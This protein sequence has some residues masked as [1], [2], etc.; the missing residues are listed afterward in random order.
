MPKEVLPKKYNPAQVEPKV[1][2]SWEK[3]G[4]FN[5]DKLPAQLCKKNA[6]PYTIVI[7]PPNIT[8]SL[9]MGH[10]LN[11]TIQDILTRYHRMRG[12]RTLW[13]PGVDHAGI[14]TQ[15][16]VEKELKKQG[17]TRHDIGRAE[18]TK[19]LKAWE[20]K[21]M[22]KI[23][24]QLKKIGASCDWS[25]SRY[26]MDEKYSQAV[27]EA[28]KEYKKK[29]Y[30][31]RGKRIVNFCPR[32]KTAISDIEVE[33]KKQ[34]DKLYYINY[35]LKNQKS[36]LKA[37]YITIATT[38]PETMLGDTAVAVNPDD[39]RYKNL[40]G[41]KAVLP[42][43]NRIIPII[44]DAVIDQDFGTGALKVTPSHDPVDFEL[45]Q[46]HDL[47]VIEVIDEDGNMTGKIPV[48]YRGID[49]FEARTRILVD[50]K[51]EGILE[52]TRDLIHKVPYCYRCGTIIEPLI[53]KQWFIS[54]EKLAEPAIKVVEEDKIKFVPSRYKKVYLSWMEN[55][56]DWCIS[57]QI[58]WGHKLP[59]K[60]SD[61]VLDTWFSSALWPFAT[62]GWPKRTSDLKT[63][64]PTS[65]LSTA[66]DIIFLWVARMVFSGMFFM[67]KVP[68]N[69]VFI[70]P[71]ILNPEGRRMSKSLGT[72]VDPLGL[73]DEF[74]A[75]ATRFGLIAKAGYNQEIKFTESSIVA[76]R[77]FSNKLLNATRFLLMHI[78]KSKVKD[79]NPGKKSLEDKVALKDK[80]NKETLGRLLKTKKKVEEN[81]KKFRFDLAGDEIYQFFWHNFCDKCLEANKETLFNGTNEKKKAH[82]EFLIM[83]LKESLKLAHPFMPFITEFLWQT[84]NKAI[85]SKERP[86]IITSWD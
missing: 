25:R 84:L 60:G 79:L 7:P 29:G 66:K 31:K 72:G 6:K 26:T 38:R 49:R 42:L 19:R 14:A 39:R 33:Y 28:F 23:F 4:Y 76:G 21:Y 82:L 36:K 73:I 58:W 30:I 50:L 47:K 10:A 68:F 40:V 64:Y 32:C 24:G 37:R 83:I 75:D 54:M 52:K 15:N 11:S 34:K 2:E 20:K 35:K 71:T 44:A 22:A 18:M 43:V 78:E 81:I 51:K 45:S 70:H 59:I 1:Y 41:K 77:N 67:K 56:K 27:Q 65:V 85:E 3:D 16:V 17:K 62:L 74:G 46:R 13:L 69:T 5:P 63:F 86:L 9:H 48:K 57:R 55:I 53:S 61:D 80:Q 12:Y 8:G